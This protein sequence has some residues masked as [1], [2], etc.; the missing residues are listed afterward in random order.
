MESLDHPTQT[1]R[2]LG[3]LAGA[4]GRIPQ[5]GVVQYRF[6]RGEALLF[7]GEVKDTPVGC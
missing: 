3:D 7:A 6:E 4:V 1:G 5:V 2:F